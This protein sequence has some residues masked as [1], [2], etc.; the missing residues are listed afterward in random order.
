ML[1]RVLYWF[2]TLPGLI[3]GGCLGIV[4]VFAA[5]SCLFVASIPAATARIEAQ[6][7]QTS[8]AVAQQATQAVLHTTA[9]SAAIAQA[10]TRSA[11][12]ASTA[13]AEAHQIATQTAIAAPTAT[14]RAYEAATTTAIA[15][16]AATSQ[17]YADAT[18]TAIAQVTVQAQQTAEAVAMADQA[19]ATAQANAQ[20]TAAAAQQA[21]E[22]AQVAAQATATIEDYRKKMPKGWWV[23]DDSGVA[24]AVG[25][26]RYAREAG[27]YDAEK[28]TKFVAF[29][30]TVFNRSG[31]E[32]H[33]NPLNVTLVDLDGST[34]APDLMASSGYWSQPL[35]GVDVLDGNQADGGMLFVIR[36][37]VAPAQ[38]V[39]DTRKLFGGKI[40]IDLKR[41]P[42]EAH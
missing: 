25:D 15:M 9:T 32:I 36:Q 6:A 12:D 20:A 11:F 16:Q 40:V 17:A 27:Y 42:D 23:G 3:K 19:T 33:V 29:G 21:T 28:G 35:H 14:A 37:D 41:P 1:N 4:G 34:Y 39:Y 26:F 13:T 18:G 22:A 10:A 30:I 2:I 24:V 5:C 38:I 8:V 7:T 31:S